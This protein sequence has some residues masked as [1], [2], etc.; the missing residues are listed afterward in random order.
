MLSTERGTS[1]RAAVIVAAI[2][3]V[4]AGCG[5]SGTPAGGESPTL[6]AYTGQSTDY[7]I[8]FNP[9]SPTAIGGTGTIFQTLF[10]YNIV[11]DDEPTPRL[12][13]EFAWNAD[14]TQLS[15]TLQEGVTWSDWVL[16]PMPEEDEDT[17][18]GLLPELTR[19]VEV[20]IGEGTEA[21]MNRFNR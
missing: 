13:K 2:A 8:N 17:V 4:A 12:G 15:I 6:V 16:A 20:W 1:A 9:F 3:V 7:Q 21:A 10:F 14:G 5:S 18:V 19:A 11:R